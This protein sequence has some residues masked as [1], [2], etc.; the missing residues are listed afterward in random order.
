MNPAPS[1]IILNVL[2]GMSTGHKRD[3]IAAVEFYDK[4]TVPHAT[5]GFQPVDAVALFAT[6]NVTYRHTAVSATTVDYVRELFELPSL[7]RVMGKEANTCTVRLSNVKR[8][9]DNP[10][11]L[12][13]F[14]LNNE[15]EG[16]RML[17]RV[18]P[19]SALLTAAPH[20]T[21]VLFVGKCGPPQGFDRKEGSITAKQDLGQIEA[22]IPPKEF[23]SKCPLEFGGD[24][25]LGT[26]LLTDKNA[27]YQAAFAALGRRG[28]NKTS[29]Q[30]AEFENLE[31]IQGI[32]IVQIQ[33]SFIHRPHEGFLQKVIGLLTPGS[34][35]RRIRVGSSVQDGTP[36]GK[37]RPMILGRWQMPGIPIQFQD[38]GTSINFRIAFA[39]GPIADMFNIRNNTPGFSQPLTVTKHYGRYGGE[40][41][42]GEDTTLPPPAFF[43]RLAYITG[44]CLGSDIAVEDPAPEISS[45]IAGTAIDLM[46][47]ASTM[48]RCGSGRVNGG[49][50]SYTNINGLRWTDNPVELV[51]VLLF[52]DGLLNLDRNFL[53]VRRTAISS[54]YCNGAI[55]DESNAERLLLPNTETARAGVDYHR[56]NTTS[57]ITPFGW[58]VSVNPFP[59]SEV[60]H[61]ATYEFFD[62][63]DPPTPEE[64]EV[65]TVYRKRFTANI[66]LAEKKKVIDFLHDVL[67]PSCRGFLS[68]NWKGEIGVRLER[69]ADSALLRASSIVG[70]TTLQLEDVMSWKGDTGGP[71]N[72][73][74]DSLIGKILIG[75]G[76]I[77]SEVRSVLSVAFTTAAN[78]ITLAASATGGTTATASG[79]TLTGGSSTVRA[80]GTITIG[81]SLAEG[82]TVTATIDGIDSTY[83]LQAGETAASVAAALGFAIN[84]NLTSQRYVEA[85]NG[86]WNSFV[87]I[88]SK[89]GVVT[90][91]S[92]LEEE[93]DAAEE[94]IR[95]MMSF[96]DKALTYADTTRSNI[97]DGTFKYLGTNGQTRYNQFKG[98]YH[99]P[100]RD[101]AEQPLIVNDEDHQ[102]IAELKPLDIDLSAVDNYNQASRLLNGANAKFGDGVDFFSWGSNGLAL[103]LEEG[104]VVCVSHSSGEFRN[105]PVR[106]EQLQLN[107]QY[108]VSFTARI[109]STSMFNDTVEQADVPI[110]SGLT[111]FASAPPDIAFDTVEFPPDGLE[112]ATDGSGGITSI[113]GG[114]IFGDSI[115]AQQGTARLIIRAGVAVSEQP[116]PITPGSPNFEFVASAFG[117]YRV[118]LE[119]CNQW[120]C[121]STKPTADIII[122]LGTA[123][124][125][126]NTPMVTLS[127]AGSVEWTGTGSYTVPMITVSGAGEPE[128]AGGGNFDIP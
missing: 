38:I 56:Y 1:S 83:T 116:Q 106:N 90:L 82:D 110:V 114:A 51:R 98:T 107:A 13:Q 23:Q 89:M 115:Y 105:V 117:L 8:D 12:A 67:L 93:H 55:K 113:R 79:G 21:L 15:V 121:N 63:D 44:H 29:T 52:D 58:H 20:K 111:N 46:D 62:P 126:W 41:D 32:R 112:Q 71:I 78:S 80:S 97:L 64:I 30:C 16:M 102:E 94:T 40:A 122:G 96:A 101:F 123:Q 50:M 25:C 19:R 36:Y 5:W 28:C 125:L 77:T 39:H 34:G 128:P 81:G 91:S 68:W 70:A 95:V 10:R 61:E 37:A 84:A 75:V 11:P 85:D 72:E 100:L 88:K 2:S 27:A 4:D 7:K 74:A 99:D 47:T 104:D 59:V 17:I 57:M 118:E 6:E 76:L 26:E 120:G 24:E 53:D 49:G 86:G 22:Q 31:F 42:Q 69:P 48:N 14:V 127:G 33:G 45:I 60:N 66:A 73:E 124:G 65:K 119:V 54:Q 9:E 92:A 108:E 35:K 43:S 109:Y 3:F 87:D 103:Q 18:I